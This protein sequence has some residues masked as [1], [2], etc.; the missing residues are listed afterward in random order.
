MVYCSR[1]SQITSKLD[2]SWIR[3]ATVVQRNG[4]EY[5]V[6]LPN[7][8]VVNQIHPKYLIPYPKKNLEEGSVVIPKKTRIYEDSSCDLSSVPSMDMSQRPVIKP[9]D[10]HIPVP[11]KQGRPRKPI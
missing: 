11:R 8:K 5:L 2:P 6:K 4:L 10:P 1:D 3:P 7:G 9:F